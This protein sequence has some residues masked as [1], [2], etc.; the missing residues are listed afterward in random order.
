YDLRLTGEE[1]TLCAN[2]A[3]IVNSPITIND[4]FSGN[5]RG[6]APDLGAFEI[7]VVL[8]VEYINLLAASAGSD[9]VLQW[10]VAT[11]NKIAGFYVERS[12]DGKRFESIAYVNSA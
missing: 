5:L 9:V 11:Q 2:S 10:E 1:G 3:S 12:P 4:D 7:G 6:A 8:P